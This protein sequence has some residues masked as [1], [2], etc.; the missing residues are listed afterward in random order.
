MQLWDEVRHSSTNVGEEKWQLH[1]SN[2]TSRIPVTIVGITWPLA[3]VHVFLIITI[4][5]ATT[6]ESR[7]H[8][9]TLDTL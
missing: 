9:I 2:L 6:G 4:L 7:G 5:K 3:F 8:R 1:F